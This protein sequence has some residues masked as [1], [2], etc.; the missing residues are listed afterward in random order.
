LLASHPAERIM[1][2]ESRLRKIRG[3]GR[4][5]EGRS[6]WKRNGREEWVVGKRKV[7]GDGRKT[8]GR[9]EWMENER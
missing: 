1:G 6:G 2:Y 9:R 3:D 8:E 4:K 5:T 7:G